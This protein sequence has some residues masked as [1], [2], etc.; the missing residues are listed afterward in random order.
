MDKLVYVTV[1]GGRREIIK[2]KPK[3]KKYY[4]SLEYYRDIKR[5]SD[6]N[7]YFEIW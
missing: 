4:N 2:L 5:M 3:K 7:N 6:I 1:D